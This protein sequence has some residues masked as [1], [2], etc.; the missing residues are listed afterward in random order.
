MYDSRPSPGKTNHN[1]IPNSA[2]YQHLG[3]NLSQAPPPPPLN[4]AFFVPTD[5]RRRGRNLLSRRSTPRVFFRE[6]GGRAVG[7][8]QRYRQQEGGIIF[9]FFFRYSTFC[10]CFAL[11]LF[12]TAPLVHFLG[13]WIIKT[14]TCIQTD[15][16]TSGLVCAGCLSSSGF[17]G[18][19]L[20]P[21]WPRKS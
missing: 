4:H 17:L 14:S 12:V 15:G 7:D 2:R 16:R 11:Y 6:Q 1:K 5:L 20:F 13:I 8:G 19:F 10:F 3:K 9:D 21:L 18:T